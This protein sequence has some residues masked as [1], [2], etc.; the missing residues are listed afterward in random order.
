MIVAL[1]GVPGSS[2]WQSNKPINWADASQT[3]ARLQNED[4]T[5]LGVDEW[6]E[7]LETE[8]SIAERPGR[9][10]FGAQVVPVRVLALR[11]PPA[12]ARQAQQRL[13]R[14][15][16][17]K[18]RQIRASTFKRAGWVILVSTLPGEYSASELFWL[19]R[20]RLPDRAPDRAR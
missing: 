6:L 19:Y 5:A 4:G 9:C 10:V 18:M 17:R 15:A 11:L 8:H 7:S 16:V 12:Q 1:P 2:R 14:I 13:A 3:G 20:S